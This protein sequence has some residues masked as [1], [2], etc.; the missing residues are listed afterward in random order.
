[1]V[2]TNEACSTFVV[3]IP[4]P[5]CRNGFPIRFPGELV[6]L[7]G[8]LS[9][10]VEGFRFSRIVRLADEVGFNFSG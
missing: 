5:T 2:S 4:A 1:M 6:S 8:V 7:V 9:P 3:A 10:V